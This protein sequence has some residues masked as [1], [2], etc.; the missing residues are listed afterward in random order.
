MALTSPGHGPKLQS[1]TGFDGCD[2]VDSDSPIKRSP[3]LSGSCQQEEARSLERVGVFFLGENE[4][5]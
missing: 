2:A 4:Y 3:A 5:Q 1:L